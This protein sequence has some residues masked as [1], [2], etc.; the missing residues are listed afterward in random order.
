MKFDSQA[1]NDSQN[2]VQEQSLEEVKQ[3][4]NG[5][6]KIKSNPAVFVHDMSKP[7]DELEFDA[8]TPANYPGREDDLSPTKLTSRDNESESRITK[9][10]PAET[11]ISKIFRQVEKSAESNLLDDLSR[12]LEKNAANLLNCDD[13]MGS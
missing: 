3:M 1:D 11:K 6:K 7:S 13:L 8:F 9:D 5:V 12:S 2:M 4:M 10:L